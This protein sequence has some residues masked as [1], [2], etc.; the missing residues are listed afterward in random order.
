MSYQERALQWSCKGAL[1][2]GVLCE[3]TAAG[4]EVGLLIVVGG[5]QV[6]VG[7]HRQFVLMARAA[8]AAGYPCLRFDVRGMGDAEGEA[9][10]FEQLDADIGSAIDALLAARPGLRRVVLWGLCDAASAALLYLDARRDP[11]VAGLCLLNPWVRSAQ[12]QAQTR[13]K[14]YYRQRLLEASFWRKLLSGKVA[15]GALR[16]LMQALRLSRKPQVQ[17]AASFQQRMQRAWAG[18]SGPS[19]LLL[20]SEDYTAKEFLEYAQ[21]RP[22]WQQLLSSSALQQATLEGAD[23][24]FSTAGSQQAMQDH[25]LRWLD[26]SL[27]PHTV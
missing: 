19:L 20:S 15:L 11:R 23:H 5:P 26:R 6:R 16:E 10:S 18:F 14:H 9:R 17:A 22:A 25:V 13:V 1:L 2:P 3:P 24:T 7:S 21:A 27:A 12:S 4:A 8:A